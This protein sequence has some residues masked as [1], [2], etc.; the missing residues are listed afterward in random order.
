MHPTAR[1]CWAPAQS[2]GP[3]QG[4][5]GLEAAARQS[6]LLASCCGRAPRR[7][8]AAA[9]GLRGRRWR[10]RICASATLP[11][12]A[13]VLLKWPNDVLVDERKIAGIL[14]E[15][16]AG[17]DGSLD[18]GWSSGIGV[19]LRAS[20]A[21]WISGDR[22]FAAGGAGHRAGDGAGPA[23]RR[24]RSPSA[25]LA[26][27]RASRRSARTGWPALGAS[28]KRSG[29]ARARLP[30]RALRRPGRGW[31]T[32]PAL[33]L[34]ETTPASPPARFFRRPA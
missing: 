7:A 11:A 15:A 22:S 23:G 10:S 9:V 8:Q 29:C 3:G 2:G 34:R 24:V 16:A 6:L 12:S 1:S 18:H 30:G 25:G 17:Q 31:R 33:G 21:G 19:N 27:G 13:V 32:C 28:A 20:S 4:R 14:L 26:D 5:P